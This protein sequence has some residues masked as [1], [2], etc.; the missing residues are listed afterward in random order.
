MVGLGAINQA[1]GQT[2]KTAVIV[3]EDSLFGTGTANLLVEA[4]AE[5]GHHVLEVMKHPTPTLDFNNIVLRIKAHNPDLS[6]RPTTTTN[7]SC[8]RAPCSSRR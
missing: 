2:A 6:S 8:S 4:A 5:H 3:H 7:T 1:A